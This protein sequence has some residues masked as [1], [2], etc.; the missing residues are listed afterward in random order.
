MA[1]NQK[2]G[3]F[4]RFVNMTRVDEIYGSLEARSGGG[5]ASGS[6]QSGSL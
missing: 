4:Y 5:L 6:M 3:L 1:A 2:L